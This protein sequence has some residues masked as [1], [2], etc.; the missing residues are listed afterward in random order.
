MLFRISDKTGHWIKGAC[1]AGG[2]ELVLCRRVAWLDANDI[3]ST[4]VA[5]L[6]GISGCDHLFNFVIPKSPRQPARIVQAINRPA[7]KAPN[8]LSTHGA[9]LA[10][11]GPPIKKAYAVL[12][13]NEQP[14][15]VRRDRRIP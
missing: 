5:K 13:D 2:P 9:T 7:V 11:R 6:P 15:S 14:V 1:E 10:K 4:P 3:R 8:C 12:N